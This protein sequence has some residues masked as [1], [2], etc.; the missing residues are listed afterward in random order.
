MRA[1]SRLVAEALLRSDAG[2]Q[3]V[4]FGVAGV[5]VTLL[6]A[7]VYLLAATI[8]AVPPLVA[9]SLAT[10]LGVCVGYVVHSRWSFRAEPGRE[11]V[12]RFLLVATA[13]F[14][15]NSLW[16]WLAVH[17]LGLPAWTPI[18]AM[19]FVTPLASFAANRW[20]VFA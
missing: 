3:L 9:N 6:S 12:G 19:V 17:A 10:A 5:G 15:L 16:V 14:A 7:A 1:S 11:A 18:R 2:G 8:L 20:W 4:R 13:G